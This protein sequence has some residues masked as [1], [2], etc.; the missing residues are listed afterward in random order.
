MLA[1]FAAVVELFGR[2]LLQRLLG[3]PGHVQQV[4]M[5]DDPWGRGVPIALLQNPSRGIRRLMVGALCCGA[6]LPPDHELSCL[7][8]TAANE[9]VWLDLPIKR[10]RAIR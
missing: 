10:L 5:P 6:F 4:A 8:L 9:L 3:N 1:N 7:L 2:E